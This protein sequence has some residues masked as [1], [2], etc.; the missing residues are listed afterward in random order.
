MIASPRCVCIE[1]PLRGDVA[2]NVQYADACMHDAMRRGEAPFLG[3]LLYPRIMNDQD[4]V[5]RARGIEA[6][7]AWLRRA[8]VVA[9]YCDLG[10][11]DGMREAIELARSIGL[12]CDS[13]ALGLGWMHSAAALT[14]TPG[15]R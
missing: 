6:H 11:T 4:A 13:R 8:D 14:P 10:V 1:S 5:M 2:R 12:E 7:L 9:V 15:F 3:H